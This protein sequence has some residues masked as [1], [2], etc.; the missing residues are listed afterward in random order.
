MKQA[1]RDQAAAQQKRHIGLMRD[2]AIGNRPIS[3]WQRREK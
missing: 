1:D 3:L 2:C